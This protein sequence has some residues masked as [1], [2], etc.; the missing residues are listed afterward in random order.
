MINGVGWCANRR[1]GVAQSFGDD[2]SS[3]RNPTKY[4]VTLAP[5]QDEIM[6]TLHRRKIKE[7][8]ESCSQH[9]AA[10]VKLDGWVKDCPERNYIID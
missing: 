8:I 7:L 10:F 3:R 6:L 2:R 1:A 4:R 5:P 9:E